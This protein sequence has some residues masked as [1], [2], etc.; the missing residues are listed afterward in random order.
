MSFPR[1][2]LTHC[3]LTSIYIP[4]LVL[5]VTWIV[6]YAAGIDWRTVEEGV[7]GERNESVISVEW[8]PSPDRSVYVRF[9]VDAS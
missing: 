1:S 8:L 7:I 4:T 3:P 5:P 2:P 9:V 6:K